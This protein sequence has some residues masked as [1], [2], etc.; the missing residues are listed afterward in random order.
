[1]DAARRVV[2]LE[3]GMGL[4]WVALGA[5]YVGLDGL[6]EA[7]WV[8]AGSLLAGVAAVYADEHDVHGLDEWY[9]AAATVVGVVAWVTAVG[10][11]VVLTELSVLTVVGG[12]LAGLGAGIVCYRFVYGVVRPVP[13][14]RLERAGGR[15][16]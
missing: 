16:V 11:V 10:I 2:L 15:S 9:R 12:A 14:A 3:G 5:L 6:G 4:L 7:W 8:V 13:K 1:M